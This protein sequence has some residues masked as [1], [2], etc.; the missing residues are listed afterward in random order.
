MARQL[1]G[2]VTSLA[3]GNVVAA[4][5]HEMMF[6]YYLGFAREEWRSDADTAATPALAEQ[7]ARRREPPERP[8]AFRVGRCLTY[9]GQR[10]S[11][12]PTGNLKATMRFGQRW[13]KLSNG[14]HQRLI[15]GLRHMLCSAP[16]RL[17]LIHS[18]SSTFIPNEDCS[19]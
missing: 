5:R 3:R 9:I 2:T 7:R 17:W 12:T 4:V 13:R 6:C 11:E 19:I 15:A 8:P 10:V 18:R 1:I 16:A 14:R